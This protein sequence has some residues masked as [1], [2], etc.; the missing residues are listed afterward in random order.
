MCGNFFAYQIHECSICLID[1]L[2]LDDLYILSC[3]HVFCKTCLHGISK[4]FMKFNV[5]KC[6]KCR[7]HKTCTP[8]LN[9]DSKCTRCKTNLFSYSSNDGIVVHLTCGHF[10]CYECIKKM[11]NCIESL[12]IHCRF[13][14]T[15][16]P[17]YF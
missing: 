11:S 8:C 4:S 17:V 16:N 2:D 9:F 12:C 5:I 14:H 1:L 7:V 3:G 6:P 10:Y 15:V 13:K